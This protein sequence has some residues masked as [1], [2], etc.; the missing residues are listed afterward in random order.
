MTG[1]KIF[2]KVCLYDMYVMYMLLHIEIQNINPDR[3]SVF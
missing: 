2:I 3:L 1:N